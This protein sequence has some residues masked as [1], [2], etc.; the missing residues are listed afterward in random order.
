MEAEVA[1][2]HA[3]GQSDA[4]V[5]VYE[6]AMVAAAEGMAAINAQIDAQYD[7][8]YALIMLIEDASERQAA[9]DE[10]NLKYNENRRAAALEYAQT[11]ASIVM[12]VWQ[13]DDIQQAA[14]D[15]DTLNQKLREY[16]MASESEKPALLADLQAL[17]AGMDEGALTEYLS[18]MTQIQSLLDSGMSEAEVQ[19]LFPDIDFSTQL[20]QFA[21]IVDYLDL[22]KTDLPGLYSMFGEALPEEVL[23]IATDL[24]MSGAQLSLIHI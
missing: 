24:D 4:D 1:R 13:Q 8:E 17:S 9:L 14:A 22:I 7:K 6:N 19:A 23:K 5:S 18:L 12:P 3:R 10:L 16:S 20:D 21:G 15:I 2:A 11:M